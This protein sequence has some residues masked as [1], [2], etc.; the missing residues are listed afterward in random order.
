MQELERVAAG[1]KRK[2]PVVWEG[3]VKLQ[4]QGNLLGIERASYQVPLCMSAAE[5][6]D[7]CHLFTRFDSLGDDP[8][9]ERGAKLDHCFDDCLRCRGD[10]GGIDE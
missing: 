6:G 10:W 2:W 8:H 1:S 4:A 7:D 3:S 5:V 9:A